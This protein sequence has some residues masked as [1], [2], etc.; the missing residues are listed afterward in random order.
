MDDDRIVAVKTLRPID[1][2]QAQE[3]LTV[4]QEVIEKRRER[5]HQ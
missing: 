2:A 4:K 5:R 1:E 3:I